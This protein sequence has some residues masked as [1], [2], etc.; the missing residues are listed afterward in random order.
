[1]FGPAF[2]ANHFDKPGAIMRLEGLLNF[3]KRWPNM[4][5]LLTSDG[6]EVSYNCN[7]ES[8]THINSLIV[9]KSELQVTVM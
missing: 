9:D 2:A 7:E 4:T 6:L 5:K 8:K 3:L 1:M